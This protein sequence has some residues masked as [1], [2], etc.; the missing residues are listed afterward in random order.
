MSIFPIKS[1][2]NDTDIYIGSLANNASYNT[3]N[4]GTIT[5]TT[6]YLIRT[7][8][9]TAPISINMSSSSGSS[10]TLL[11]GDYYL[12]GCDMNLTTTVSTPSNPIPSG[13]TQISIILTTYF[14]FL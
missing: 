4:N 11:K 5:G 12:S 13:Y 9:E 1:L 10:V 3:Y 6:L 7:L 2:I 14:G 8:H